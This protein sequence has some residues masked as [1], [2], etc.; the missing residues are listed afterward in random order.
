MSKLT[1]AR[2]EINAIDRQMAELFERRM[3]AVEQICAFKKENGLPIEDS[4]REQ[5]VIEKNSAFIE[6][7]VIREYYVNFIQNTMETSK[8]YQHRLMRGMRVAYCGVSGAFAQIASSKIFP[9]AE[10]VA[11]GDFRSAYEAALSGECDCAVLPIENS[12]AGDVGQV[13][14]ILFDGSLYINGVYDMGVVHN[15]IAVPGTTMADIRKVISHPQALAQ[16]HDYIKEH[17][18]ASESF[19][20]TALAA[21]AVA[22][23]CDKSVAAIAS[24]QTAALYGLELLDHDINASDRNTTRFAVLSRNRNVRIAKKSD[25]FIMMLTVAD[26]T[27]SLAKAINI[28]SESG[29]NMQVLRSRPLKEVSWQYYFFIEAVGDIF[30]QKGQEMLKELGQYCNTIKLVGSFKDVKQLSE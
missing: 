2:Q 28:I 16:C 27:G 15:L 11:F 10:L 3:R 5:A 22:E 17:G 4:S 1:E 6:D 14:D 23:V 21:K 8:R 24:K 18:F 20:N 12:Y 29:F 25:H 7:D 30:S 13:M 9:D 19:E 26:E